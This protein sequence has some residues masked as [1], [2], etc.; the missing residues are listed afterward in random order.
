MGLM[1]RDYYREKKAGDS[2]PQDF[3]RKVKENPFAVIIFALILL[4]IIGIIL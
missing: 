4:L 1:D 2:G 3:L